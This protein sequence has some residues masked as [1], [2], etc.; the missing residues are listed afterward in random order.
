MEWDER[1][2]EAQDMVTR[3]LAE[4]LDLPVEEFIAVFGAGW[5]ALPNAGHDFDD[6]YGEGQI[7]GPWYIAGEPFQLMLRV[8]PDLEAVELARPKGIWV[9]HTLAWRPDFDG[10]A[11]PVGVRLLETAGPIVNA[12]LKR[13]RQSFRYCRYCR[14]I[15]APEDR[16]DADLCHGCAS[17]WQGVVY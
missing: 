17:I 1:T 7:F 2:D 16:M 3:H 5:Q 12:I 15:T 9:G 11:V 6:S 13:R 14:R 10:D 4:Q 8:R